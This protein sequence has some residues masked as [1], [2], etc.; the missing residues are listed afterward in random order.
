MRKED[1]LQI[2]QDL[3]KNFQ[4]Q[5]SIMNIAI[6]VSI[7]ALITLFANSKNIWLFP[8]ASIA[9]AVLMFRNFAIMHEAVHS[10]ISKHRTV[11]TIIGTLAG[12]ICFLPYSGWKKSHL[13]HHYWTGNVDKD[14]VMALVKIIPL[15]PKRSK[16][17]LDFFWNHW[18]PLIA[19]LQYSLFWAL[20]M[21]QVATRKNSF[22]FNVSCLFPIA[23]WATVAISLPVK[24]LMLAILPGIFIYLVAVEIVNFPHHME[25]PQYHENTKLN[26]WDQH[27]T[28]RSCSYPKFVEQFIVLNF[29]YHIEH[30]MFPE[31]PWY[32]LSKLQKSI[33][34]YLANSYN[35]DNQI[36]WILKNRPKTVEEMISGIPDIIENEVLNKESECAS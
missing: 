29:N 1:Y 34:P 21:K 19:F 16:K 10:S 23:L 3:T 36:D 8:L 24:F 32:N 28:S 25:L 9:V 4:H 5:Y 33:R 22:E 31:Q 7:L 26:L 13:E 27:I 20:C 17:T 35:Q 6:D 15:M 14:P 30:H 11:N 2:R 12:G 18:I